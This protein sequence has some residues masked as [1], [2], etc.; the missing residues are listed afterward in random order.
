MILIAIAV[1]MLIFGLMVN[2]AGMA[3]PA[4]IVGGIGGILLYQN[5]TQDWGS[6]SYMWALIPGFVGVGVI[7]TGLFEGRLRNEISGGVWLILI[8]AVLFMTFGAWLGGVTVFGNY[9]PIL[10]ILLGI[11]IIARNIF[12]KPVL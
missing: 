9:W 11:W 8:S 1:L 12:H 4:C 10:L 7:L 2:A 6:W 5:T 3:V